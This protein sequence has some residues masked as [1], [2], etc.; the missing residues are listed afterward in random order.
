MATDSVHSANPVPALAGYGSRAA[1]QPQKQPAEQAA[2]PADAHEATDA[3]S[4]HHG[5]TLG[6]RLLRERVLA[7]TRAALRLTDRVHAHEFA[8]IVEGEPVGSFLGR[9]LS[10]QNQLAAVRAA[11]WS[12]PRL[13]RTLA[14]AL[15]AG[16]QETLL[17]LT[18]DVAPD[19]DAVSVVDSVLD[20]FRRRIDVFLGEPRP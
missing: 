16:V 9:L 10:A 8:E 19:A 17:L 6:L 14:A 13:R 5:R 2:L 3:V 18:D 11:Q 7:R 20:E 1:G 12:A 4:V 15:L